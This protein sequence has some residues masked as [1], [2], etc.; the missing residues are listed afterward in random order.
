MKDIVLLDK[1]R[2]YRSNNSTSTYPLQEAWRFRAQ[3]AC[4]YVEEVLDR[5]FGVV[6]ACA[7]RTHDLLA[8]ETHLN[9]IVDC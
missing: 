4:A 5:A 9:H 7:E 6:E 1:V 2:P 3:D 8:L